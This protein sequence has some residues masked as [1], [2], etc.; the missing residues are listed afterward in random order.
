MEFKIDIVGVIK[1]QYRVQGFAN[2]GTLEIQYFFD[3]EKEAKQ[4]IQEY[5]NR[6]FNKRTQ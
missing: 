1:P 5:K 4:F 6:R 2:G 3:T